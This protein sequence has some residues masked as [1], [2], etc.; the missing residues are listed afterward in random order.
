MYF[1]QSD[2]FVPI[3][4]P[5]GY[6]QE[7]FVV[8]LFGETEEEELLRKRDEQFAKIRAAEALS[9]FVS[10][11]IS[12]A[13]KKFLLFGFGG[14]IIGAAVTGGMTAFALRSYRRTDSVLGPAI[15]AGLGSAAMGA[16]MVLIL[17]RVVGGEKVD[18]R[19]AALAIGAR[20]AS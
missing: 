11:D 3:V 17:S 4:T 14:V 5:R 8:P 13:K 2:P 6:Q 20:M 10:P 9:P 1:N 16:A 12:D 18:P 7:S 19:V 15:Y